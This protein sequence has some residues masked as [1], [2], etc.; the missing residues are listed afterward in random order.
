MNFRVIQNLC[1][2]L[3]QYG[4]VPYKVHVSRTAGR[5]IVDKVLQYFGITGLKWYQAHLKTTAGN[6]YERGEQVNMF[7]LLEEFRW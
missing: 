5:A 3:L 2:S 1:D 7:D 6:T 4:R